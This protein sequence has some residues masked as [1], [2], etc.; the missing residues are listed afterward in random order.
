MDDV[1]EADVRERCREL[2]IKLKVKPIFN[3]RNQL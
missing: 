1:A 2:K 3:I